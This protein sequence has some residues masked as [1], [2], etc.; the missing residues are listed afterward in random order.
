MLASSCAFSALSTAGEDALPTITGTDLG[1]GEDRNG[2]VGGAVVKVDELVVACSRAIGSLLGAI[3]C[4]GAGSSTR[5]GEDFSPLA[6]ALI[7]AISRWIS[8]AST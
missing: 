7:R 6:L 3:S 5:L 8:S 4:V 1:G 2:E